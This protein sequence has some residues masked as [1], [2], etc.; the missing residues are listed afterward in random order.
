MTKKIHKNEVIS[1]NPKGFILIVEDNDEQ[2]EKLAEYFSRNKWFTNTASNGNDALRLIVSKSNRYDC[3]I[4]DIKMLD[5]N[6]EELLARI[7]NQYNLN[8]KVIILSGELNEAIIS[9][10]YELGSKCILNKPT[11]SQLIERIVEYVIADNNDELIKLA[12]QNPDRIPVTFKDKLINVLYSP[13][14]INHIIDLNYIDKTVKERE[15]K[16]NEIFKRNIKRK[17]P[18]QVTEPILIIGRQWNSWYPAYF[19]VQGGSYALV[20]PFEEEHN[21]AVI[22]PG[23]R[24]IDILLKFG[25]SI[26]DISTC[27]ISHNHPD[28]LGDI[29][30]YLACRSALGEE[31]TIFC[32][33]STG[34]L[35]K[36][37][38]GFNLNIKELSVQHQLFQ[39]ISEIR[40]DSFETFHAE[41]GL[42]NSSR[43]IIL[44]YDTNGS[45]NNSAHAKRTVILG[46]TNYNARDNKEIIGIL[47][48]SKVHTI[49]LHIG[50]AQIK[51]KLGKHLYLTGLKNIIT[52]IENTANSPK[53]VLV[54]EW[55]LE[56][57]T[58]NQLNKI[59]GEN[60]FG[61][62]NDWSPIKATI[63]FLSQG[64]INIK[65][66]PADIGLMVG[67]K[68]GKIYLQ[69]GCAYEPNS[70]DFEIKK[71][72]IQ[73]F[74]K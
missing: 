18:F 59:C 57:A 54:S 16:I 34:E 66:L 14:Q 40:L 5:L 53:L 71:D 55:G 1:N 21:I 48:S 19:N 46:D 7:K 36:N 74:S 11:D 62:G 23:F 27:I 52:D 72:G 39:N 15:N 47:K 32:N 4:L 50:S 10:C 9:K 42:K 61:F 60:E 38:A 58:T 64:L 73:Y 25:I 33:P 6:G 68:T 30:N 41:I 65:L 56:H 2:R 22:D 43:G 67:T 35:L 20:A 8:P 37:F 69:D 44:T 26:K 17:I 51:N 24:F 63:D 70:I 12:H 31:N 28:H 3:I 13:N 45:P 29:F 49:V